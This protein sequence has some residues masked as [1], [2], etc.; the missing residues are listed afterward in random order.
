[1][2][3]LTSAAC[4]SEEAEQPATPTPRPL[5]DRDRIEACLNPFDGNHDGFEDQVRPGLN[6]E[7]SMRTHSTRF[8]GTPDDIRAV[9][10]VMEYSAHNAFGARIK[11]TAFGALDAITCRVTVIEPG[12]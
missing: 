3:V 10:I 5:S 8:D 6:D 7:G 4:A 1:M 11:T 12:Y 9:P 2:L